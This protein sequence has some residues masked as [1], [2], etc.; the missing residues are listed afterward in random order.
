[1]KLG[2]LGGTFDPV[3]Y[4][5]LLLAET[6]RLQL[7]LD[8]VR[9]V[10]AGSPPHK[11]GMNITDGHARAD[12]LQLAV[13]GY[14]EFAVDRRELRREGKSFTVTTLADFRTDFVDA[15]LFFL[16]G[17]DSLRDIP[18][19]REPDRIFELATVVAVNRPG[20]PELMHS[21]VVE[22]IGEDLAKGV[23]IVTMPGTDISASDL[24]QRVRD[25]MGLR[26]LVPRAVEA[27][28][29]QHGL[30]V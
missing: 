14:P 21:Q 23:K 29:D 13:S 26:F 7:S 5:H 1:M 6:C 3:H 15:E 16:L 18:T 17:A 30:Y 8:Q 4:G 19:W 24:R 2:I 25:R 22:W 9:L 28:I 10:P 20:L 27:F 11:T 12:M